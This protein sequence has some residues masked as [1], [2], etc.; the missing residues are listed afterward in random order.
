[1]NTLQSAVP[2]RGAGQWLRINPIPSA[3]LLNLHETCL[4]FGMWGEGSNSSCPEELS[5]N[6]YGT[7]ALRMECIIHFPL[8]MYHT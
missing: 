8:C 5:F 6:G 4:P 2:I 1:M 3:H 7:K